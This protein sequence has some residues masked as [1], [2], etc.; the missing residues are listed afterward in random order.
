[1][2]FIIMLYMCRV[3]IDVILQVHQQRLNMLGLYLDTL[4]I[5]NKFCNMLSI[6]N[7][8]TLEK[9]LQNFVTMTVLFF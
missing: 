8:L 9:D 5:D 6:L 3:L 4:I 2:W 1:M 7:E